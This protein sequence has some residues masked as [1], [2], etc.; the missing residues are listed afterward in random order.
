MKAGQLTSWQAHRKYNI[1][2]STIHS[3]VKVWTFADSH[4]ILSDQMI[5]EKSNSNIKFSSY[6]IVNYDGDFF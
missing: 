2:P 3:Q 5:I 6:G 4:Y 1:P